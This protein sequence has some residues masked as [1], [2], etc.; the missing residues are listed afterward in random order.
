MS[1]KIPEEIKYITPY[2]QRGQEVAAR[3]PVV[4]YYGKKLGSTRFIL[5]CILTTTLENSSILCC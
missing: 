3:D 4:S 1:I 2:V 5:Q